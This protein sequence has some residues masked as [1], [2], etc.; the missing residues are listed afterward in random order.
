LLPTLLDPARVALGITAGSDVAA[1]RI[2]CASLANHRAVI[3]AAKLERDILQRVEMRSLQL[4]PGITFAHAR[5][6]AVRDFVLAMTRWQLVPV[7][8][9]PAQP[10]NLL[11]LLATPAG[12]VGDHLAAV[13]TLAGLF[14]ETDLQSELLAAANPAEFVD[15]LTPHL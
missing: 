14:Y 9:G 12:R 6:G 1:I 2:T 4:A 11:I 7:P 15:A 3:D 13:S 10:L 5:T 8:P